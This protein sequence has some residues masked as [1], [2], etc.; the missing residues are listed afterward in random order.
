MQKSMLL[1][2]ALLLT[3]CQTW[4]PTW[5]EVSGNR[6]TRVNVNRS[7]T[8]IENIDGQGAFPSHPIK[9]E[10]GQRVITLQGVP[11]RPGWHGGSLKQMTLNAKP[12]KRYYINAQFDSPL[13]PSDWKPVIDEVEPIGGCKAPSATPEAKRVG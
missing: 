5:S 9:I 13:S 4:G 12:C 10:P 8:I 2:V 1:L 7:P 6:Y 11:L 3:G